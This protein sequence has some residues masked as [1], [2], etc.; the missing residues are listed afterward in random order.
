MVAIEGAWRRFASGWRP[1]VLGKS[2]TSPAGGEALPWSCRRATAG[3]PCSATIVGHQGHRQGLRGAPPRAHA[4]PASAVGEHAQRPVPPRRRREARVSAG[5]TPCS[6]SRAHRPEGGAARDNARGARGRASVPHVPGAGYSRALGRARRRAR[7]AAAG[8]RA[9]DPCAHRDARPSVRSRA[10]GPRGARVRR[11]LGGDRARARRCR[12]SMGTATS[13]S[14][15]LSPTASFDGLEPEETAALVSAIVYEGR[16]RVPLPGGMPTQPAEERYELLQRTWRQ[17]RRA[18]DEHQVQ[19]CRDLDSGFA[20][21]AYHWAAGRSLRVRPRRD[22]HGSGRLR[23]QLQTAPRPAAPDGRRGVS[24][25]IRSD[26]ARARGRV[27][28]RRRLY[29]RMSR[30]RTG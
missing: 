8:A 16:E 19:L 12:G 21:P 27:P 28:R 6:R 14:A 2:W 30:M 1:F 17:V 15:R 25:H 20:I 11:R 3:R 4:D 24:G 10:D 26:P 5:Q 29:G 13:S 7:G 22:R 9:S 23:A 18:E